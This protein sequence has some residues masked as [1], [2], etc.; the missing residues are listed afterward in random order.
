MND[1]QMKTMEINCVRVYED[2]GEWNEISMNIL[3]AI[4]SC[5]SLF[6]N[7]KCLIYYCH[8]TIIDELEDIAK[9]ILD[10]NY[11]ETKN[12]LKLISKYMVF[13]YLCLSI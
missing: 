6:K 13:S 12:K 11:E 3:P 4:L 7:L 8:Y 5:Y 9:K 1:C 10:D 2:R